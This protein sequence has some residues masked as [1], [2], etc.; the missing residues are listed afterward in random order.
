[1]VEET[2]SSRFTRPVKDL[3]GSKGGLV[4]VLLSTM[5]D[6]GAHREERK[7]VLRQE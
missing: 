1:M 5:M 4:I 7:L 2:S 6:F 3:V